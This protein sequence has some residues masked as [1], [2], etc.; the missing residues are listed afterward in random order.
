MESLKDFTKDVLLEMLTDRGYGKFKE[1]DHETIVAE[2]DTRESI[3]V[4]FIEQDKVS[5]ERVRRLIQWVSKENFTSCIMIFTNHASSQV[6]TFLKNSEID[7]NIEI[8][9]R[10]ELGFNVSKHILVPKHT[11]LNEYDR[12]GL[13]KL[14]GL[15]NLPQIKIADPVSKYYG[16]KKGDI[17]HIDRKIGM[18]YRLVV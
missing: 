5:V 18:T 9:D 1:L 6:K 16:A 14:Y 7:V 2:M 12:N 17:F 15:K 8:F 4:K 3:A 10:N 13:S 11:L